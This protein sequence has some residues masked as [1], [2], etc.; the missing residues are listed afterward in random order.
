MAFKL[1]TELNEEVQVIT[2][3]DE[4]KKS[5]YIEGVFLQGNIKNKNGRIYPSH[6]LESEVARYT[7]EYINRNRALGELG[8]PDGPGID[9]DRV[10]H[11]IVSLRKEGDNFIG[12]A[13]I[14]TELPKGKIVGGLI[15]EGIVVAV[16]SR[17]LGTLRANKQGIMEVQGDFRLAT[18]ADIVYDPS[19]PDAFVRGIMENTE[20][21][22][23]AASKSWRAIQAV[24]SIKKAGKILTE[25]QKLHAFE[26]ILSNLVKK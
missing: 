11:K 23:E 9:Y 7:T 13:K 15:A 12:K 5:L 24:E 16:S 10:S 20:W 26:Y 6:V 19:A 1:I 4:N 14:L 18:A 21:V 3:G 25:Q 8:H 2:E 22:Y 17:G